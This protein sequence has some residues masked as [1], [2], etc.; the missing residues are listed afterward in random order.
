MRKIALVTGGSRGIG[1]ACAL[2][3]ARDGYRVWIFCSTRTDAAEEVVRTIRANGGDAAWLQADLRDAQAVKQAVDTILLEDH[4]IDVLVNN[5]GVA[6][7]RLFTDT[8][9]DEWDRVFDINVRGA[10]LTTYAVLPGMISRQEGSIVNLSSMWG[11]VGASC[12]VA[13]S[14][15]KAAI[16]GL[17]K[18]LAKEVGPSHV[19]VNC[20]SPGTIATE[21]NAELTA[22]DLAALADETPLGRIG[23]P[24][25]VADCVAFLASE[26]AR[27]VTGQVLGVSGGYIV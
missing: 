15:S 24:E 8:D 13:Y 14:A 21:M 3:L 12:E 9:P 16:I 1:R 18:A 25:E 10:Y 26:Q 22:E 23:M 5:A 20:V 4:H 17:T 19:R 2:R 11:E 27:F 6:S 7:I